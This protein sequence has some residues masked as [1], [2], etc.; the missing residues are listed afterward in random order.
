MNGIH[1]PPIISELIP[2]N[3]DDVYDDYQQDKHD[4]QQYAIPSKSKQL[5]TTYVSQMKLYMKSAMV[6]FLIVLLATMPIIMV[7][8][9]LDDL[10]I[11]NL[12]QKLG[13]TGESYVAVC[14]SMMPVMIAFISC[15]LCG[16]TLPSE[17][18]FRTAYLNLPLPQLRLTF[19]F[20]KYLAGLTLLIATIMMAF[21]LA[22]VL[23]LMA[24]YNELSSVAVGQAFLLSIAGSVAISGIVYGMSAY[25]SK[26]SSMLPFVIVFLLIPAAGLVITDSVNVGFLV[27]YIP[28]F[29]GNMALGCLGS[30]TAVSITLLFSSINIDL[31]ADVLLASSI[32]ILCGMILLYAGYRKMITR[33][34]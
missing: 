9:V 3:M 19:Y 2:E 24:G 1:I 12:M 5:F 17:F 29:A 23:S 6:P 25:S 8:G 31:S 15:V 13:Y 11:N 33:E 32:N 4:K 26:G 21:G 7:T 18:R 20:G 22:I 16:T 30:E 10:L 28:G 34:V 27:G 14:L